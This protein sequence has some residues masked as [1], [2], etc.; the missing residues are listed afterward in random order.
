MVSRRAV[1][2]TGAVAL[3]SVVTATACG[4]RPPPR[5]APVPATTRPATGPTPS[6]GASR[7]PVPAGAGPLFGLNVPDAAEDAVNALAEQLGR[8]PALLSRFVKLDSSFTEADLAQTAAEGRRPVVTIE[9]WSYT[10]RSGDVD[11][12]G[13]SLDSIV[14]GKHDDA[15]AQIAQ[16]LASCRVPVYVRFAHEMNAD[17]YP[18]GASVNGN[19]P[20]AY[21]AAWRHTFTLVSAIAP[22]TS[23]VWAP[24]AAWWEDRPPLA[25][26]YPGDGYVHFVG[27]TGYG[28]GAD[29]EETFGQ[30]WHEVRT[31]TTRPA[32]LV[33]TGAAGPDK[34]RW[35]A[36]LATFLRAH[37]DVEA[38]VWFNTTPETTGATGDYRF[39]DTEA[40]LEA[41]RELLRSTGAVSG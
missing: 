40:D 23:W 17:W 32:F 2:G 38:F 27:A 20:R 36:S 11:Q 26:L 30:W 41:F 29:A 8:R 9:P 24:V 21:V 1:L 3:G 18:W 15:L 10:M 19:S 22:R 5:P 14:R 13:Y 6:A 34:T 28:R 25:P 33:E 39:D 16:V 35:I 12:P 31:L 37:P 4:R 7:T